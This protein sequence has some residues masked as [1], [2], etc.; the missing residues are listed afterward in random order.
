MSRFT[1]NSFS[2][3]IVSSFLEGVG[4]SAPLFAVHRV[5]D[6]MLVKLGKKEPPFQS[7]KYEYAKLLGVKVIEN[8]IPGD[9]VL[10]VF[11]NT[12]VIEVRRDAPRWRKTFTV[13]HEIGHI[14][15]FKWAAKNSPKRSIE[16][17]RSKKAHV[18]EERLSNLFAANLIMPRKI[19]KARAS[20]LFPS[21]DSLKIL[22]T[23]F[24]ASLEA[25]AT[26]IVDLNVWNCQFLRCAPI[27]LLGGGST[28]EI[29]SRPTSSSL[30]EPLIKNEKYF[31]HRAAVA[32]VEAAAANA[33][34]VFSDTL[35]IARSPSMDTKSWRFE[36]AGGHLSHGRVLALLVPE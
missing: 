6:E 18:D 4:V 26:R 30:L 8:D 5:C 11:G 33:P 21:M 1:S 12:F 15:I 14:Q 24:D 25:T 16:L 17:A 2:S 31:S 32:C 10:S 7:D 35:Q 19:F 27:K 3:Q 20:K 9:G 22:A 29:H 34:S 28:I 23:Q 36:C 13:C